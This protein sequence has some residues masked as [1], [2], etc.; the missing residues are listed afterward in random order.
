MTTVP[1]ANQIWLIAT[2]TTSGV[3][4]LSSAEYPLIT[5][6]SSATAYSA[7]AIV[8]GTDTRQYQ[9]LLANTNVSPPAPGTW[10]F[11]AYTSPDKGLVAASAIPLPYIPAWDAS[12]VFAPGAVVNYGPNQFI[13]PAGSQ[14]AAPPPTPD[15]NSAWEFS[16][17]AGFTGQLAS[18]YVA[19]SPYAAT[20]YAGIEWY[21]AGGSLIAVPGGM[22]PGGAV[23]ALPCYQRLAAPIP[24]M[25]ASSGNTLGLTW[26]ANPVGY[27]QI[28]GGVL[29]KN[30][31]WSGAQKIKLLYV[32]DTRADCCV[33]Q[34]AQSD[35]TNPSVEDNGILFRLSDASNYWMCSRSKVQKMTAGVLSTAATYTRLPT[36]SRY[37]VQAVGSTIRVYAYPGSSGAPTLV[38]TVSDSFNSTAV[39]HGIYDQVF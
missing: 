23:V 3:A 30:P 35:V 8:T 36:G 26:T 14:G 33:G 11:S 34:T 4:A 19:G 28:T 17:G 18:F 1:I 32:A 15:S 13:A 27:W 21:D 38:T 7:G 39:R 29:V 2:P 5:S 10:A 20:V 12:T 22:T 25:N 24:E 9:A 31:S 16:T 37:Y 6:W